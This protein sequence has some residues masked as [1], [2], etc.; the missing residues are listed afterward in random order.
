MRMVS[1]P[2]SFGWLAR[3]GLLTALV[4]CGSR[5]GDPHSNQG[6]IPNPAG[7]DMRI[8]DVT[9]PTLDNHPK[10]L[11]SV[12][13]SGA[14]VVAV[15]TFDETGDGKSTGTIYVQDLGSQEPYS[16]IS[17]FA[18]TFV[19]GNLRVGAGDVLDL[20]GQYQ[21]NTHIGSANFAPG[22]ILAQL[23]RPTATFRFDGENTEPV[24]IDVEDL[25]DFDKGRK[26]LGM[27][28]RVHD[29]K[30][31]AALTGSSGRLSSRMRPEFPGVANG[32]DA[33]FPKAPAVVNELA[34]IGSLNLD[35]G[36]QVKSITGVVTF[37]CNLHLAPRTLAD[38]EP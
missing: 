14:A 21:E 7:K 6:V 32:C 11:D 26:W 36:T 3:V 38:I 17:L 18:P 12:T 33:P 4:A 28:V 27:V 31:Q 34:D 20:S 16:G 10:S 13:V 35:A 22:A 8:R 5:D 24:D 30:L 23:A 9:N 2:S 19:P 29:V 15:D 37:F 1:F 25:T